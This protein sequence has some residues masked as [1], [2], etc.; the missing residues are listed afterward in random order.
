MLRGQLNVAPNTT[1]VRTRVLKVMLRNETS[2]CFG[3]M[4]SYYPHVAVRCS[5]VSLTPPNGSSGNVKRAIERS[6]EHISGKNKSIE[7]DVT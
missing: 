3:T 6:S 1:Q 4:H 5:R 7:G 2:L